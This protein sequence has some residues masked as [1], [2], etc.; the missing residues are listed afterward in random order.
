MELINEADKLNASEKL[1][2]TILAYITS[3]KKFNKKLNLI[4]WIVMSILILTILVGGYLI[5]D[6]ETSIA[7]RERDLTI[8]EKL[9][10]MT[11]KIDNEDLE[12]RREDIKFMMS[13]IFSQDSLITKRNGN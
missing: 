7:K 4:G 6:R 3:Q 8:R 10:A 9:H 12:K 13:K 5:Y 2:D 11:L 1:S